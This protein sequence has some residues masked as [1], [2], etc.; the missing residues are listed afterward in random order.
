ME[1]YSPLL[2]GGIFVA[3]RWPPSLTLTSPDIMTPISIS[4]ILSKDRNELLII[5]INKFNQAHVIHIP[6]EV[7]TGSSHSSGCE[8]DPRK[9]PSVVYQS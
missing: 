7:Q 3:I 8:E 4:T 6:A 5:I 2:E 1:N 9:V